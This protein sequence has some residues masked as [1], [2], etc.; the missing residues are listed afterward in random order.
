VNASLVSLL[1]V[2][3]ASP[4][5]Q[6]LAWE[7]V[8][9]TP[10][11][12]TPQGMA[13]ID[14]QLLVSAYRGR[15]EK[16]SVF[17]LNDTDGRHSF[18]KLFDM[19]ADAVHTGGLSPVPGRPDLLFA[20][21]YRS[22]DLYLIDVPASV[23]CGTARVLALQPTDMRGPSACCVVER[24]DGRNVVIVTDFLLVRAGKVAFFDYDLSSNP[25]TI[26]S[27]G[28]LPE[29]TGTR[30]SQGIKS[31]GDCLIESASRVRGRSFVVRY[32]LADALRDGKASPTRTWHGPADRIED[33]AVGDGFLWT[34]DE[35]ENRLYRAPFPGE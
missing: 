24:C 21:D 19:P 28:R 22:R 12:H 30:F 6:P 15:D 35:D 1:L 17:R 23:R 18:C 11:G 7:A 4:S 16:C 3:A 13:F 27:N 10:A 14:G 31:S 26:R 5:P 25:P 20:V 9:D 2:V 33:I 29:F 8:C 34:T 32:S